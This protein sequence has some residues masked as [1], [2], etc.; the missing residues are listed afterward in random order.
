MKVRIVLFFAAFTLLLTFATRAGAQPPMEVRGLRAGQQLNMMFQTG[1]QG[2]QHVTVSV[3][4]NGPLGALQGLLGPDKPHTQMRTWICP[5]GTVISAPATAGDPC[6][7]HRGR[8]IGL[9]WWDNPH[10]VVFDLTPGSESVTQ[11]GNPPTAT[12]T[13]TTGHGYGFTPT[14][15][16]RGFGGASFITDNTPATAGFDGAVLFPLGNRVLIGPMAGFQWVGSS[17][18]QTIGG[19]PPPSTFINTTAGFKQGNFGGR[20]AFPFSGFQFGIHGGATVAGLTITQ[21]S[22]FCSGTGGSLPPGCTVIS[23]TTTHDTGVGAFVGTYISHPIFSHVGVFGEYDY[24]FLPQI[25]PPSGSSLP[26]ISLLCGN[27]IFGG[28]TLTFGGHHG[29]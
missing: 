27:T 10:T 12:T 22:G 9:W 24:D 4:S 18:V 7:D 6:P 17:Q 29:E 25:K 2:T 3:S 16:L 21:A 26:A 13:G 15:Q 8:I 23:T 5:D 14:I 19:G 20:I 28:F 1:P 11:E